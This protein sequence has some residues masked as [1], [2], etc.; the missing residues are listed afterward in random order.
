MFRKLMGT[1][2]DLHLDDSPPRAWG[3]FLCTRCTKMLG[4]FGGYSR[5]MITATFTPQGSS[6]EVRHGIATTASRSTTEN[7]WFSFG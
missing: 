5:R 4:W 7:C 6:Q 1:T 2:D 3:H